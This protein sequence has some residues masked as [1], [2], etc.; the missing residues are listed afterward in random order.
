MTTRSR[1][2]R[3]SAAAAAASLKPDLRRLDRQ[4]GRTVFR[5]RGRGLIEAHGQ[6]PSPPEARWFSA[7]AAA[8]SLKRR[9]RP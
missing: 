5:G 8:A 4:R 7:A 2:D 6:C 1:E 3:F 9:R